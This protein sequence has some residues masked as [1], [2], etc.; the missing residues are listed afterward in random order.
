MSPNWL[1]KFSPNRHIFFFGQLDVCRP[2][3]VL[4]SPAGPAKTGEII[5]NQ[6]TIKN[7]DLKQFPSIFCDQSKARGLKSSFPDTSC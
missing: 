6:K 3:L 4:T 5:K 1:N 7:S 2:T